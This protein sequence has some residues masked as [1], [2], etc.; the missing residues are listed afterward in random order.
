MES[1]RFLSEAKTPFHVGGKQSKQATFFLTKNFGNRWATDIIA[2]KLL[3]AI[4]KLMF[5]T[6]IFFI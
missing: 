2:A 3:N 5:L 1:L 6:L 4:S